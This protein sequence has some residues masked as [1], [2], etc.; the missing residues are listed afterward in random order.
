MEIKI[1]TDFIAQ[2]PKDLPNILTKVRYLYIELGKRSFYDREYEYLMFGEEESLSQYS[3]KT[4]EYPNIIICTTLN[5]QFLQLLQMAGID[6]KIMYDGKHSFLIFKDE[7]GQEHVTDL[8]KDLKNIQFKC[9]TS[10]FARGAVSSQDLRKIDTSLGYIDEKGYSNDYWKLLRDRLSKS[11]LSQK[12]KLELALDS[13]QNFGDLSKLGISEL[14][15]LYQKFILY[16]IDDKQDRVFYSYKLL[17]KPEE[18][19]IKLIA[20]GKK[21]EYKLNRDTLL[22]EQVKEIEYPDEKSVNVK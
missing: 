5:K 21:V 12:Q 20:D 11:N 4:Y 19:Y 2:M 22:F 3:D 7:N 6:A 10:Y 16:C 14:F 1:L 9:S 18:F 17:N 15:S 8:T 13:L